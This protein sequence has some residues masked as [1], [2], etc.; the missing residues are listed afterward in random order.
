MKKF[1]QIAL[2]LSLP[3]IRVEA[4]SP[5]FNNF[6]T[7]VKGVTVGTSHCYFWFQASA[8]VPYVLELACYTGTTLNKIAVMTINTSSLDFYSYTDGAGGTISW[9]LKSVGSSV[10]YDIEAIDT[11]GHQLLIQTGTI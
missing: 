10:V 6:S 1:L 4:Q 9:L 5:V 11:N 2:L 3:L 7:T 8:P